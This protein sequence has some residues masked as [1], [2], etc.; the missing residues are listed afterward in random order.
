MRMRHLVTATLLGLVVL[1]TPAAA[2][3]ECWSG[4]GYR[5]EPES[6]AFQGPRLLLVTADDVAWRVGQPV[7]LYRLDPRTGQIDRGADLPHADIEFSSDSTVDFH[8]AYCTASGRI[9]KGGDGE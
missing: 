6:L 7:R 4:W 9:A 8:R 1:A 5:V 3:V 2:A